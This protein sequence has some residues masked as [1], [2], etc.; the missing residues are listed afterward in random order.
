[1]EQEKNKAEDF[2]FRFEGVNYFKNR[3]F[4]LKNYDWTAE[5]IKENLL[6]TIKLI[7][8]IKDRIVNED[9]DIKELIDLLS[10]PQMQLKMY[11]HNLR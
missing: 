9:L 10:I 4:K 8:E 6:R 7:E 1:M 11:A 2:L 3:D 5:E